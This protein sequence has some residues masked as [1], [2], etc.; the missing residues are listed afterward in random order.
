MSLRADVHQLH[1]TE[2]ADLWYAGGGAFEPQTFGYA[3][4]AANGE[5][6]LATTFDLSADYR[7]SD[8]VS[9]N[10]YGA[11]ARGGDVVRRLF[12]G[13]SASLGYLEIELRK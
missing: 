4:R 2:S 3:G 8:R 9:V 10:G 5:N 7:I 11:F 6:S 12:S 13:S 1:L